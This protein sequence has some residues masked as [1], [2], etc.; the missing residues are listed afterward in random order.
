MSKKQK[1]IVLI[2]LVI[3][4]GAVVL[5]ASQSGSGNLFQGALRT[6]E[7]TDTRSSGVSRTAAPI[8]NDVREAEEVDIN[9]TLTATDEPD[10]STTI[11]AR[12][13]D[14]EINTTLSASAEE[15]DVREA[16]EIDSSRTLTATAEPDYSTT[17]DAGG[18]ESEDFEFNTTLSASAEEEDV[19]EAEESRSAELATGGPSNTFDGGEDVAISPTAIELTEPTCPNPNTSA[20]VYEPG[21]STNFASV[22]SAIDSNPANCAYR[23]VLN[24]PGMKD[25]ITCESGEMTIIGNDYI[26]CTQILSQGSLHITVD[27]HENDAMYRHRFDQGKTYR[28]HSTTDFSVLKVGPT[29]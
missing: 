29:S 3:V 9:T 26:R 6:I 5:Y 1:T 12:E 2:V 18:D 14:I 8:E 16:E 25:I 22:L 28:T 19:R 10:Y 23:F 21:G 4:F 20:T 13:E 27:I 24:S 11:D 7:T 17:I 15:E